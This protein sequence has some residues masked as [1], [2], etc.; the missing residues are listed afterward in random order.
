MGTL[1]EDKCIFLSHLPQF[2]QW[3]MFQ[4]KVVEKLE[5]HTLCSVI[6]FREDVPFIRKCG[7][8]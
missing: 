3:K 4:M 5:V 7:E 1:H 8:I 2:L 6:F